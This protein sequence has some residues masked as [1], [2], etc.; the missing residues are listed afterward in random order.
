MAEYKLYD[1]ESHSVLIDP[2]TNQEKAYK[3]KQAAMEYAK[4][5]V[6]YQV[7]KDSMAPELKSSIEKN[8]GKI[9]YSN[10]RSQDQGHY[11]VVKDPEGHYNSLTIDKQNKGYHVKVTAGFP[12][13]QQAFEHMNKQQAM[14]KEKLPKEIQKQAQSQELSR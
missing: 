6:A 11:A 4:R 5:K 2:Q 3:E 1:K 14:E 8:L 10:E 7:I 13:R 12:D 9:E